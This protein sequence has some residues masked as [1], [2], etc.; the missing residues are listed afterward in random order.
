MKCFTLGYGGRKPEELLALLQSAGIRTVVDIRSAP[1]RSYLG[2]FSRQ[3]SPQSGIE[4]L[5][6]RAGIAYLALPE[7]ANEFREHDD[8][9]E[10][11]AR[12]LGRRGKKL[13]KPL[14]EVAEP[15]ALLCAEKCFSECHREQLAAYLQRQ[16]SGVEV[17]HL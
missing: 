15:I 3:K 13:V 11:Y 16:F 9:R 14:L 4:G 7:L 5:L 17:E 12:F 2:V 8:W 6:G 10:R 1:Q